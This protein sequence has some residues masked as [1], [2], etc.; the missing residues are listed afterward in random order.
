MC[1]CCRPVDTDIF[2]PFLIFKGNLL[3]L[4]PILMIMIDKDD[5]NDGDDDKYMA[6]FGW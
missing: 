1:K 5:D 2:F 3:M 4:L 6:R